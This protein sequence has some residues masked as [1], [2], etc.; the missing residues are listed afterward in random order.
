MIEFTVSGSWG[1][2]QRWLTKLQ[3]E[4][5]L[6]ILDKYG[7]E[8]VNALSNAT[9]S[10]TGLTAS[11]WY[12]EVVHKRGYHAIHWH[13]SHMEHGLPIAILIQYGHG[14][15]TGGY[16]QGRDYIM[17]A[18]RPVFDR[19]LADIEREVKSL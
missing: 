14:T 15:G 9:P 19:I 16:V 4:Q 1:K 18:I 13:N 3:D 6:H 7:Q 8:G 10:E 5:W 17:P 12:Y 2:T 11:S